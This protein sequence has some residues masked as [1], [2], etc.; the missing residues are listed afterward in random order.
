MLPPPVELRVPD[1]AFLHE[2]HFPGAP[3]VPGSCLLEAVRRAAVEAFGCSVSHMAQARFRHFVPPASLCR[4]IWKQPPPLAG[5]A[6]GTDDRPVDRPAVRRVGW[7]LV[8]LA[9]EAE[10]GA[11]GRRLAEGE[12]WLASAGGETVCD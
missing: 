3:C 2:E 4:L 12:V 6:S 9:P 11:A 5:H 10:G 1:A 8:G 7:Q